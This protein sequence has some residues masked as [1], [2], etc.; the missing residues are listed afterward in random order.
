MCRVPCRA[1]SPT[2]RSS[3]QQGPCCHSPVCPGVQLRPS[4]L[5][6]CHV[7]WACSRPCS[8][9]STGAGPDV[10]C[11]LLSPQDLAHSGQ[12]GSRWWTVNFLYPHNDFPSHSGSKSGSF[13][14]PARPCMPL[15]SPSPLSPLKLQTSLNFQ[16][17]ALVPGL[18]DH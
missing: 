11:A 12:S 7:L 4:C 5:A 17:S 6:G 3:R 18:I 15:F 1:P 13:E 10:F 2:A 14:G 16:L 9:S 8:C